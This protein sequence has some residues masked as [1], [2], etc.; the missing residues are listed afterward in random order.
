[1]SYSTGKSGDPHSILKF[2]TLGPCFGG[3][4]DLYIA[5][6]DMSKWY[7]RLSLFLLFVNGLSLL[8]RKR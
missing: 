1:M 5:L 7:L 6:D 8:S 2:P 3:G 4:Y